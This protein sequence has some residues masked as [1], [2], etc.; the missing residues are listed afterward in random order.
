MKTL[1]VVTLFTV[2]SPSIPEGTTQVSR[3][4]KT[5]QRCEAAKVKAIAFYDKSQAKGYTG[6]KGI[7]VKCVDPL[8]YRKG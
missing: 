1:L 7:I 5:E 6:Y 4:Y 2:A 8:N 3:D